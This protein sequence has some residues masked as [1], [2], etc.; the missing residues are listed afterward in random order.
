M[1]KIDVYGAEWC[2]DCRRATSYLD[3]N[4]ISYNYIDISKDEHAALEVQKINNGKRIIPTVI[5]DGKPFTNPQ[6]N[7]LDQE[8]ELKKKVV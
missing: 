8:L 6:N 1:K 7:V 3:H 2:P 4:G 5:I